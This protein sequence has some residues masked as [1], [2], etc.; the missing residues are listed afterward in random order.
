M[1]KSI[2]IGIILSIVLSLTGCGS[3]VKLSDGEQLVFDLAKEHG[4]QSSRVELKSAAVFSLKDGVDDNL[5]FDY[6]GE[7]QYVYLSGVI[8]WDNGAKEDLFY[9]YYKNG[10]SK[11]EG[12]DMYSYGSSGDSLQNQFDNFMASIEELYIDYYKYLISSGKEISYEKFENGELGYV[13]VNDDSIEK[14]NKKLKEQQ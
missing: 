6:I 10:D 14:I 4:S 2:Y 11:F 9:K 5:S 7:G 12:K 13:Y 1:K 3:S 8:L